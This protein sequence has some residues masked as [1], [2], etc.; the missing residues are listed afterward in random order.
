MEVSVII[1]TW[2]AE[3]FIK[4]CLESVFSQSVRGIEIIVVD[5]G[6]SDGTLR[7]LKGYLP[8]LQ[9]IEN[10]EN[11]GF[12]EANNQGFNKA[13]G[14]YIM[15]LNSDIALDKDYIKHLIDS[16]RLRKEVGM[17]QGKFLRMDKT[18]IDSLGLSLSPAIRLYNI[19][20]G[21]PDGPQFKKEKEIFGPCAAA[22]LYK[23]ELVEDVSYAGEFFDNNFFYLV[24]DFDVAWRARRKGWKAM[25]VPQAICYHYRSSA[26]HPSVFKQYLS[27]RNR[28]FLLIKNAGIKTLLMGIPYFLVY[29]LPRVLFL[30]FKNPYTIKALAEIKGLWP[31]LLKRRRQ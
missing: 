20:E 24:E 1:V 27:F 5:N 8:R 12:C 23:R 14:H 2:N 26:A 22:A 7:I 19:A 31:E 28:Y 15:T 6:S 25:Y 18:T 11:K 21:R 16:L 3:K 17:V 4:D 10:K 30:L 9:L 29:D 13:A